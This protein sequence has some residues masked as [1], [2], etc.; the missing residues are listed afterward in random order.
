M[1]KSVIT[2]LGCTDEDLKVLLYLLL[3]AVVFECYGAKILLVSVIE[4][5]LP[6]DDSLFVFES[7]AELTVI[8][9]LPR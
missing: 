4:L 1:V 6:S 3:T 2:L 5:L 7:A 9:N 8:H